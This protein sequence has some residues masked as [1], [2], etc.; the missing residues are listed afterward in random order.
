VSWVRWWAVTAT[1]PGCGRQRGPIRATRCHM[2]ERTIALPVASDTGTIIGAAERSARRH[3]AA[4]IS[5]Q[6]SRRDAARAGETAPTMPARRRANDNLNRLG[7]ETVSFATAGVSRRG[8]TMQ[9]GSP[10]NRYTTSC[11]ELLTLSDSFCACDAEA[12]GNATESCKRA[13][14]RH[15]RSLAT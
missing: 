3:P 15:W 5:L 2:R 13:S 8:W 1:R 9:R 7:R 12:I 10:S 14:Q 4:G 11:D 6:E